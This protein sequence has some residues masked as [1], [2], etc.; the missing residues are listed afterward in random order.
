MTGSADMPEPADACVLRV[1]LRR[2]QDHRIPVT[3]P[4]HAHDRVPGTPRVRDDY[5]LHLTGPGKPVGKRRLRRIGDQTRIEPGEPR[6]GPA[7]ASFPIPSLSDVR[8]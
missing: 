4:A 1:E 7:L 2:A 5:R 3:G 8:V 6:T